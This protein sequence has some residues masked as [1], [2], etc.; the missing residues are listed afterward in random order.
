MWHGDLVLV[1][2]SVPNHWELQALPASHEP[3]AAGHGVCS[4]ARLIGDFGRIAEVPLLLLP[5]LR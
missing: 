4:L 3:W 1:M 5:C 2:R